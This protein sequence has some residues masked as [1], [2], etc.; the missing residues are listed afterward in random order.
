MSEYI[1]NLCFWVWVT[2]LNMVAHKWIDL[3][4]SILREVTQ[5]Q[6]DTYNMYSF[7]GGF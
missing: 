7:I 4:K 1:L 5:T 6:Q 2:F 3:E